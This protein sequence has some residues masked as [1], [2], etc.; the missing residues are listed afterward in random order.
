MITRFTEEVARKWLDENVAVGAQGPA[1]GPAA[2]QQEVRIQLQGEADEEEERR[3]R[4]EEAEEKRQ[5]NALP[6]WIANSTISGEAS[7]RQL[8]LQAKEA[9]AKGNYQPFASSNLNPANDAKPDP[10]L[11]A[12]NTEEDDLEA[13]YA[14][15]AAEADETATVEPSVAPTAA[16]SSAA[17]S[18]DFSSVGTPT[19]ASLADMDE[20]AAALERE[21]NDARSTKRGRS[22]DTDGLSQGR[23]KRGR[24]SSVDSQSLAPASV[25]SD[26]GVLD[27]DE[28]EDEFEEEGDEDPNPMISVAGRMVPFLEVDEA[29]QQEMTPE[30]YEKYFDVF[31]R[32]G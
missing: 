17:R 10:L 19:G 30:E 22:V 2:A 13:Y 23:D 21:M 7:S 26:T 31:A 3:R 18:P 9:A 5:Q 32:I 6:S 27:D 25:A 24:A 20:T 11:A 16:P 12:V 8:E 29:M 1:A 14:T 28:F 15:L 4:E